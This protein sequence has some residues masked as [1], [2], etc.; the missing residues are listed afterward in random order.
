MASHQ[1]KLHQNCPPSV[2]ADIYKDLLSQV[3]HAA[4]RSKILHRIEEKTVYPDVD[5]VQIGK[6]TIDNVS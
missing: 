3:S 1:A 6:H 4:G 5:F 2:G